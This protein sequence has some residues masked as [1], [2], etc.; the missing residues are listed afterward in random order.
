MIEYGDDAGRVVRHHSLT[1]HSLELAVL[2]GMNDMELM[3]WLTDWW[4]AADIWGKTTVKDG[5]LIVRNLCVNMLGLTTPTALLRS[6]PVEEHGTGFT[7]RVMFI[8]ADRKEKILPFQQVPDDAIRIVHRLQEDL[9]DMTLIHGEFEL[10]GQARARYS[11]IYHEHNQDTR[12]HATRS[13]RV[14][15]F[16]ERRGTHLL[17]VSMALSAIENS[18]PVIELH[19]INTADQLVATVEASLDGAFGASGRS[20]LAQETDVIAKAIMLMGETKRSVLLNYFW[21]D[22]DLPTL[23]KITDSL[24]A[25][26]LIQRIAIPQAFDYRY[27]WIGEDIANESDED[28]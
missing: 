17:K 9:D 13:V 11:E 5:A 21:Q 7:S 1:I 3:S 25:R 2:L 6:I 27:I 19:H 24:Y 23:N 20:T 28:D 18:E 26:H 8:V 15:G 10:T 4:D 22:I 12:I 14:Q 16:K